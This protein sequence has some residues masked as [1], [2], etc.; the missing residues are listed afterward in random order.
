MAKIKL[1]ALA[2]LLTVAERGTVRRPALA[3]NYFLSDSLDKDMRGHNV[4][5]WN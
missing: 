3:L 4:Y 5:W 2:G 1:T